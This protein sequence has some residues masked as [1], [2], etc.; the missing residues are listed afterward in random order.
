MGVRYILAGWLVVVVGLTGS[1][2]RAE[3][4]DFS[5]LIDGSKEPSLSEI[6]HTFLEFRRTLNYQ[7]L[8]NEQKTYLQKLESSFKAVDVPA[9]LELTWT[10]GPNWK[11]AFESNLSEKLGADGLEKIAANTPSE[12]E[13]VYSYCGFA[14]PEMFSSE[15]V[16]E[17]VKKMV[18]V[19]TKP[20][21]YSL[22]WNA[23]KEK[24]SG[25]VLAFAVFLA[26]PTEGY[27]LE[28]NKRTECLFPRHVW[29]AQNDA[30]H[31]RGFRL[32][33]TSGLS[34]GLMQ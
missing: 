9:T 31:S 19:T 2:A 16:S 17:E 30:V 3:G 27:D 24:A 10:A 12:I 4:I 5:R 1:L 26:V 7:Q 14:D 28:K 6:Y 18:A 21:Q 34:R 33:P 22:R 25:E 29:G 11:D 15:D 13:N 32:I 23:V 20:D 8:S